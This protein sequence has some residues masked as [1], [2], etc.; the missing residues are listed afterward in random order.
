MPDPDG[1]DDAEELYQRAPCGYLSTSPDGRIIR[2]NDTFLGWTGYGRDELVGRRH[3]SEL[4]SAGGRIYHETHYLPTLQMQGAAREIALEIVC[5]DGD[6][7]PVLVNSVLERDDAGSP[8]VIRTAVFSAT[9]RREYEQELLRERQ[10]AEQSEAKARLVAQ[11]LQKTFIP[12]APPKIPGLDIGAA[13]RPAGGGDEIGGDFYDIFELSEGDWIVAIGDV[14]GKGVEAAVI[15]ALARH[16]IRAAAVRERRLTTVLEVLNESLLVHGAERHLTVALVRLIRAGPRWDLSICLAGHPHG[17]I[18]RSD[19][20]VTRAGHPGSLLG[21]FP[22]TL[23]DEV[24]LD[25]DPGDAL[26]LY[27]DGVTEGRSGRAFYGE[28]RLVSLLA[29][30]APTAPHLADAVVE[31]VVRY[32]EED[33]ADDV[34]IVV[35]GFQ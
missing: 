31:D 10:R 22:D 2:V 19:G 20:T 24:G 35:I 7:L 17:L 32:Q 9:A 13:F 25:L 8:R 23:L 6:R 26:V 16:T 12:P 18:R 5:E 15:T 11:T 29:G 30:G 21:L 27:T 14:C 3:F 34:A 4:L 1:D 28:E 33:T